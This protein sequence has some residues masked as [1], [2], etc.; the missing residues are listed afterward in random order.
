MA[1]FVIIILLLILAIIIVAPQ[2]TMNASIEIRRQQAQMAKT[3]ESIRKD[4]QAALSHTFPTASPETK[5]TTH[6]QEAPADPAKT[7]PPEKTESTIVAP[8]QSKAPAQESC[9]PPPAPTIANTDADSVTPTVVFEERE[10]GRF[11]AA[12]R[13]VL[14][15]IWNWIVV[16]EEFRRPGVSTEYAVATNWLV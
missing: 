3:L 5:T 12:A 4:L 2:I 6:T 8:T 16:G 10:P 13:R 11:E 7:E 9:S 14:A 1:A 15:K